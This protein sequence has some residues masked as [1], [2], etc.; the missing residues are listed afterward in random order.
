MT[1]LDK[2]RWPELM[3]QMRLMIER[4]KKLKGIRI[5]FFSKKAGFLERLTR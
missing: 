5:S 3:W 1:N 4:E 2:K